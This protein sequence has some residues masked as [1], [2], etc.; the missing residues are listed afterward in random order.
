MFLLVTRWILNR[1]FFTHFLRYLYYQNAIMWIMYL[2]DNTPH[3]DE[4][5]NRE[6]MSEKIFQRN[7]IVFFYD[8]FIFFI[9]H[10]FPS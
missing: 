4:R 6:A 10:Y 3:P 8:S 9:F 2:Y 5:Y 1:Y 7:A